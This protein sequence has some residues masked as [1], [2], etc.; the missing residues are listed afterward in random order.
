M[1]MVRVGAPMERVVVD[2]MGPLNETERHNHHILV[3]Q[4]NFSKWVEA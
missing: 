3:V 2:L 4:D 1:G